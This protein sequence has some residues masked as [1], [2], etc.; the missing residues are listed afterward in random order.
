M[1]GRKDHGAVL[2]GTDRRGAHLVHLAHDTLGI[3]FEHLAVD[4]FPAACVSGAAGQELSFVAFSVLIKTEHLQGG[5]DLGDELFDLA[6]FR[7]QEDDPLPD[8]GQGAH[9][10]EHTLLVQALVHLLK[11]G[12]LL[13]E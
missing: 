5:E 10:L 1:P 6:A 12:H 13:A 9:A 2:F 3:L 8:E 11:K 4:R 7:I